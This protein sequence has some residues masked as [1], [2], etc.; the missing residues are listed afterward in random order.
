VKQSFSASIVQTFQSFTTELKKRV[1]INLVTELPQV[2]YL[3]RLPTCYLY[4]I[5]S[6]GK[7]HTEILQV[8]YR[9]C[10]YLCT[11]GFKSSVSLELTLQIAEVIFFIG[12]PRGEY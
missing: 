5:T 11:V 3:H 10:Y 9:R 4:F 8:K 6:R 12:M 7:L 2:T 1:H